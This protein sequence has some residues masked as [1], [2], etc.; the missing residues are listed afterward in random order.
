MIG[1]VICLVFIVYLVVITGRSLIL[2]QHSRKLFRFSATFPTSYSVGDIAKPATKLLVFGDSTAVGIGADQL[3]SSFSYRIA[4]QLADSEH[5]IQVIN[6]ARSGA[7]IADIVANQLPAQLP[8]RPLDIF[9]SVGANDATHL[10]NP[11]HYHQ[12][13]QRI[14]DWLMTHPIDRIIISSAPD[15]GLTPALPFGFRQLVGARA[16][17]ENIWLQAEIARRQLP[18]SYLDIYNQAKLD[19]SDLYAADR[20]HP[21]SSGYQKWANLLH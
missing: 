3:Q 2:F 20:F 11:D 18:I 19:R 16:K 9:I 13:W 10:T 1:K 7:R 4:Q 15:M 14:F 5:Q 21:S 17:A 12:S 6:Y 8:D